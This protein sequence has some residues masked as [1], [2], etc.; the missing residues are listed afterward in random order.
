MSGLELR[1]YELTFTAGISREQAVAFVRS[2]AT[3]G[4]ASWWTPIRPVVFELRADARGVG[5]YLGVSQAE[6]RALTS[7]LEDWLPGLAVV[8]VV[9]S[10]GAGSLHG[11]SAVELRLRSQRRPLRSELQTD[12]AR[13]L[14]AGVSGLRGQ[15]QVV[16][17]WVV[18][19]WLP[20]S[21]VPSTSEQAKQREL[22]EVWD[23]TRW[24]LP[25]LDPEQTLEARRKQAEHL[26]ACVGRVAVSAGSPRRRQR[27]ISRAVGAF[28]LLRV[29]GAGLSRRRLPSWWVRSRLERL[30][31]NQ[32]DP[33]C[34]LRA[35][36]LV[37]VLGWPLSD[38]KDKRTVFPGVELGQ[39]RLLR[40][41]RRVL[42][43]A[44]LDRQ[45]VVCQSAYPSA[46]GNLV[47]PA[48]QALRHLHVVGPTGV[49]KS[50]LL[51]GLILQDI[52]AGRG[53][54]VVDP[55]GDLVDDI[56]SRLPRSALRRVAVLDPTDPAPLGL[57][58]LLTSPVSVSGGGVG[59]GSGVAVD[60]L[61]AVMHSLWSGS[62]G[63]R[64]HDVL[65]AGLLT[66]SLDA[67]SGEGQAHTLVE[68]PLLLTNPAF[69]RPLVERAVRRD[70]VGLSSFWAWFDDL[71][72]DQAAQVLGPVMNKLRAF[73]L[74]PDLRAVLG[75]AEPRFDL[76]SVFDPSSAGG[77]ALL[78]RLPRGTLGGEGSALLGSLLV[79]QVWQATLARSALAK[80]DRKPVF[81]YLDEFQ[82]VLRLPLDL[83]DAL[84]Q[85]RGL[86]VG[87]ILAHQHLG[88][89]DRDVRS[90]VLANAGSRVAFGLDYDD[91]AV[92]A[93][94]SGGNLSAEDFGGLPPYHAYVN[95]MAEG[96]ARGFAS[97]R[98]TPLPR[99]VRG[100][101]PVRAA[102]RAR[103]GVPR[104][105]TESRLRRLR[106][107]ATQDTSDE[108]FGV[109]PDTRAG[110]GEP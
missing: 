100:L 86:G 13:A 14:L 52:S 10:T 37:A 91:A 80:R 7:R 70:P 20:R 48:D 51:A 73:I 3:R 34:V 47:L 25:V 58:P 6:E 27:L 15:E 68:L 4:R 23:V 78:V 95:L 110:G 75:Q 31:V 57:N 30:V 104:A 2:L 67:R 49:G 98:T 77:G 65:H 28:Q 71:S 35:D 41:D 19:G 16:V 54:V 1:W 38:D 93:R 43:P 66:L 44:S 22:A 103:Y 26:F 60:G 82:E 39:A 99:A 94:R 76:R 9:P 53:V 42:R 101:A 64:L 17:Q 109:L 45:R 11:A 46:P 81:V 87:L 61:L 36:E 106:E 24:G 5:W 79:H 105:E 96:A 32:L 56:L 8:P 74:R 29:S 21:P 18:G 92:M 72:G 50:T 59:V 88:Q 85:S 12:V 33:A 63:P 84:V 90:A 69:R 102:N 108:T 107:G 62:W 89:L 40:Q 97:G 83:S 55:K